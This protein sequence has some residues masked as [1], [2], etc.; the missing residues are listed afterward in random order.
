MA[1][2]LSAENGP[3]VG[4]TERTHEEPSLPLSRREYEARGE[5]R[6]AH[7]IH[8]PAG[9]NLQASPM[10]RPAA[11]GA[12]ELVETTRAPALPPLVQ[13][14]T[15]F[16]LQ[17]ALASA[18]PAVPARTAGAHR[19]SAGGDAAEVHVSIGRIELTAVHEAAPP[20]RRAAPAR[21]SVPLSEYLAQRQRG[22]T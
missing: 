14:A 16:V 12:A 19:L 2:L 22:R 3:E 1:A 20:P 11:S 4:E 13:P 15:R 17:S 8:E 6:P 10:T 5:L 18:P 7:A 9:Q 21:K